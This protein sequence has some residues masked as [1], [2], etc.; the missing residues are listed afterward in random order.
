MKTFNYIFASLILALLMLSACEPNKELYEDLDAEL[1]PYNEKIEYTLTDADYTSLTGAIKQYKAFND[2]AIAMDYVPAILA[3]KFVALNLGSA[4]KVSYNFM[5]VDTIKAWEKVI[6]GYTLTAADYNAIGGFIAVYDYFW[7]APGY[8]AKDHLPGYLPTIYPNQVND[9]IVPIIYNFYE[10]KVVTRAD[11]YKFDGENL[12]WIYLETI[13]AIEPDIV[14]NADNYTSMGLSKPYFSN[15]SEAERIIPIWLKINF[16]YAV[17]G[18]K[19]LIQYAYGT[20]PTKITN[21]AIQYEYNGTEWEKL[22]GYKIEVRSEQYVFSENGWVFDPT[23]RFKMGKADYTYIA[24]NDPISHPKYSDLGYYYGASGN[25]SNF[26]MRV[27][28]FHLKPYTNVINEETTITYTP[29]ENDPEL[30]NLYNN[31]GAEAVTELLFQRILQE[32]L[33]L[34]LEHKFPTAKPLSEGVEVHYVVQFETYHDDLS[35]GYL[36]AEYKCVTAA[37][38]VNSAKFEFVDGP[39]PRSN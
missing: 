11:M 13:I 3:K 2:T 34:L 28:F 21:K 29:E 10:T 38:G 5:V 33:I 15:T 32:G 6:F 23:I 18:N 36:E 27:Q 25:Y 7:N 37:T 35:R 8:N 31:E 22:I 16:P 24:E 20:D 39:R 4:A 14:F 12:T 1:K 26:D 30:W 9:T 19:Q 17:K